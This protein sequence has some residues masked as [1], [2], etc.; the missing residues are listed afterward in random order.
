MLH[1][2]SHL[3]VYNAVVAIEGGSEPYGKG[4]EAAKGADVRAAVATAAYRAAR[5][6][7]APSQF[8]YLD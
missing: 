8:A 6:R 7:V 2:I 1:T 3:A 4:V 5:G